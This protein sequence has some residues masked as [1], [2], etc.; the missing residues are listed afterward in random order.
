M[1]KYF[2]RREFHNV[3]LKYSQ[4]P[5]RNQE[6]AFL[7]KLSLFMVAVLIMLK[8]L[9]VVLR[10]NIEFRLT[11]IALVSALPI[12][13]GSQQRWVIIKKIDWHT[14]VFFASMFILMDS[15][16]RSG[17]F[18]HILAESRQDL[19]STGMILSV[20]IILSQLI[21]N[22]PLVALYQPMLCIQAR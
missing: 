9:T 2:Y 7:S 19:T 22:V 11:T 15:V 18:Q 13:I 4:V 5:V 14:L 21:S 12:L 16:W 3:P 20:S 1:L 8:I 6:L 17:F 10:V